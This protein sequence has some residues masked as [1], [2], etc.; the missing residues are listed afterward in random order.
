[1]KN[2]PLA[3]QIWIVCCGITLC[4][5]VLLVSILPWTLR[6]F[7]T[8]QIYDILE[9][10]QKTVTV[11]VGKAVPSGMEPPSALFNEEMPLTGIISD[12]TLTEIRNMPVIPA[13]EP[14][15]GVQSLSDPAIITFSA[16]PLAVMIRNEVPVVG[17]MV[18]AGDLSPDVLAPLPAPFL[19]AVEE[20]AQGQQEDVKKYSYEADNKS[21]F[22][23]IRKEP[24]Q[25]K[26]GYMV[27]Y[28]WGNYRNDLVMTMFW[29]LM[30]LMVLVFILSSLPS[31]W[32][33][34]YLSRPLV[35]MEKHV[36]HIA[37]RNWHEPFSLDRK[38]EIGKLARTFE[39]MRKRLVRQDKAQQSFLQHISH[40]LKTP[41]MVI[42]SYAQSILDGIYPKGNLDG[43]I[44]VIDNEAE[45][46]EKR[47]RDLLYLS[48]LNYLATRGPKF[49]PFNFTE[50][51]NDCVDRFRCRRSDL[52]WDLDNADICVTGDRGQWGVAIENLL[53]NQTR[54]ADKRIT[55]SLEAVQNGRE[56]VVLR[57]WNDGPA[58]EP[59]AMEGMF[60]R[61]HTGKGGEFGLG[62]AIV[63]HIADVQKAKIR[64][65]NEEDGVAF[66]IEIDT[67]R[68]PECAG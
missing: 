3:A 25:G 46:L 37:E 27:S 61:Y 33:A 9:D 50:L 30:L 38:D 10:S 32:L 47:I 53:D 24:V 18:L 36:T 15:S 19:K 42:R 55:I 52:Q 16:D 29:R 64:A 41:V 35:Q 2:L 8:T 26:E 39:N 68:S 56:Q 21:L 62:L 65:V 66:Y 51:V 20:D 67:L 23:V 31:L 7:F 43:S 22:Y 54:F 1:M 14:E 40:E 44:A 12:V 59:E 6:D 58:I 48:K 45:R 28:A 57:V 5:F 17:H 60:E 11:S 4:V 34:R 49:E 13:N 63:K